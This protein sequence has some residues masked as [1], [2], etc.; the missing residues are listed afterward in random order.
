MTSSWPD[1]CPTTP[2][3]PAN[4]QVLPELCGAKFECRRFVFAGPSTRF[5]VLGR[6]T[7]ETSR[8]KSAEVQFISS[9]GCKGTVT[10]QP[11]SRRETVE[12]YCGYVILRD[13]NY[14]ED[15]TRKYGFDMVGAVVMDHSTHE[16]KYSMDP[17]GMSVGEGATVSSL[18]NDNLA[19]RVN[20][21]GPGQVPNCAFEHSWFHFP[22][23]KMQVP[24]LVVIRDVPAGT[25]LIT[26]YGPA[27]ERDY[28]TSKAIAVSTKPSFCKLNEA[29][30]LR[31]I[32]RIQRLHEKAR[33][34]VRSEERAKY[35]KTLKESIDLMNSSDALT[36][37]RD[38]LTKERD[39]L[40]AITDALTKDRDQDARVSDILAGKLVDSNNSRDALTKERDKLKRKC[41]ALT[42]AHD[43]V[44]ANI[45]DDARAF[46]LLVK[47]KCTRVA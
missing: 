32:L 5:N 19:L 44:L 4:P 21:A 20:E 37:E 16:G 9:K 7:S 10:T 18:F 28:A 43:T 2:K 36:K 46:A 34:K 26:N 1:L 12:A 6:F 42:K 24:I 11:M 23:G 33:D 3:L 13:F 31:D 45:E 30:L 25:E 22:G 8:T 14:V 29:K 40:K 35:K 41:D 27:Y 39:E 15:P 38:A 17:G 47:S